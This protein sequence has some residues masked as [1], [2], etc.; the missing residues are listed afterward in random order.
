[1]WE[2]KITRTTYRPP[3]QSDFD[4]G[5]VFAFLEARTVF[6]G[7][8]GE[9]H[10]DIYT[11]TT[12]DFANVFAQQNVESIEVDLPVGASEE[13]EQGV[14][15][16]LGELKKRVQKAKEERSKTKTVKVEF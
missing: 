8:V 4:K 16:Y 10:P 15:A 11:P 13:F 7:F 9:T 14:I 3:A 6:E 5:G 2:T 1:M 12:D